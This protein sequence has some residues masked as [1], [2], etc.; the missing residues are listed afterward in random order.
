MFN[1]EITGDT[2]RR[3]RLGEIANFQI[4]GD[5][6][7]SVHLT[8]TESGAPLVSATAI[9]NIDLA[10][11]GNVTSAVE[12]DG[13]VGTVTDVYTAGDV[14]TFATCNAVIPVSKEDIGRLAEFVVTANADSTAGVATTGSSMT[15]SFA[16]PSRRWCGPG[17]M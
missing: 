13:L 3:G 5:Q 4:Y 17:S 1:A 14:V 6:N 10:G 9:T 12:I 7:V 15:R 11:G 2:I 16:T 8:G